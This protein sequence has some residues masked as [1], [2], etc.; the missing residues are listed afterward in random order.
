M[1][2]FKTKFNHSKR[3]VQTIALFS[4]GFW[5]AVAFGTASGTIP[6][7]AAHPVLHRLA[8]VLRSPQH[9]SPLSVRAA[10]IKSVAHGRQAAHL[11]RSCRLRR[12]NG[13]GSH[14]RLIAGGNAAPAFPPLSTY[15]AQSG[16]APRP[17]PFKRC[18]SA[19]V[20]PRAPPF[21]YS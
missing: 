12:D 9:N 5:F 20:P 17:G 15:L 13:S 10:V 14:V 7:A 11:N 4:F 3:I 21:V 2:H 1:P 6:K 8:H 19:A 18:K 16:Y